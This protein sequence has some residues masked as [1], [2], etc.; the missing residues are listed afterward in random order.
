MRRQAKLESARDDLGVVEELIHRDEL[1]H[2][3]AFHL[4][5]FHGED[6]TL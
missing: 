1:T 4:N 3:V 5:G 2:M 6:Q